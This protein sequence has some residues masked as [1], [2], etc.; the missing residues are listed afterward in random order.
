VPDEEI[1][2]APEP[3]RAVGQQHALAGALLEESAELGPR[4][5]SIRLI[6]RQHG[7]IDF[8]KRVLDDLSR[9]LHGFSVAIAGLGSSGLI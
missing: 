3:N 2:I 4:L 1:A 9:F 8:Q 7:G 6:P 5:N